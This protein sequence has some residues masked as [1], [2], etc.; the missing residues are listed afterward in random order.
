MDMEIRLAPMT[1]SV[2]KNHRSQHVLEK[3][4]FTLMGEENSFKPYRLDRT[5]S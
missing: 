2:E 3:L 4:V 1:R 5:G